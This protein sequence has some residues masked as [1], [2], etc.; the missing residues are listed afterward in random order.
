LLGFTTSD[1]KATVVPPCVQKIAELLL[2]GLLKR[3]D[4][5][6]VN[7]LPPCGV[8]VHDGFFFPVRK[9]KLKL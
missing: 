6:A 3:G 1:R 9:K 4:Q 2:S 7:H 8:D 5:N